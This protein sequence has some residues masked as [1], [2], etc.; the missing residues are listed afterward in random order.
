MLLPFRSRPWQVTRTTFA[1]EVRRR[2]ADDLEGPD[3]AT[4]AMLT[5]PDHLSPV[6]DRSVDHVSE[7]RGCGAARSVPRNSGRDCGAPSVA[8]Y[9]M[10]RIAAP[11]G[12]LVYRRET[13]GQIRRHGSEDSR[14]LAFVAPQRGAGELRPEESL[15]RGLGEEH[16]Q[17]RSGVIGGYL[18]IPTYTILGLPIMR[19][20][21]AG[22]WACSGGPTG[23]TH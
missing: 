19:G 5:F 2:K 13:R 21:P 14:F 10:L 22:R 15:S 3:S 4:E 7:D 20:N 16:G 1:F 6:R 18:G 12:R 11:G 23:D 8:T 9:P 17:L